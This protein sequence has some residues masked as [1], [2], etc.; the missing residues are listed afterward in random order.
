ML[1]I[2][3]ANAL[4]TDW[5]REG[6]AFRLLLSQAGSLEITVAIPEV[7]VLEASRNLHAQMTLAQEKLHK[8]SASLDRLSIAFDDPFS[9]LGSIPSRVRQWEQALRAEFAGPNRQILRMPSVQHTDVFAYLRESRPPASDGRGYGDILIWETIVEALDP[10]YTTVF[11]SA[12]GDFADER[13]GELAGS[14]VADAA[15]RCPGAS[16]ELVRGVK[17]FVERYVTPRL[18]MYPHFWEQISKHDIEEGLARLIEAQDVASSLLAVVDSHTAYEAWVI[19]VEDLSDLE[20]HEARETPDGRV[21]FDVRADA[22]LRVEYV[23]DTRPGAP[24]PRRDQ[25]LSPYP[26]HVEHG[27]GSCSITVVAEGSYQIGTQK[28]GPFKLQTIASS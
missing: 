4:M 9:N 28:L 19:G 26:P 25:A 27:I 1:A 3:D 21:F 11:I 17:A 2:L 23:V 8:V 6:N 18:P 20:I 10:A 12:D 24:R 22:L 5:Q 14:L 13:G 16:V 7:V 15:R